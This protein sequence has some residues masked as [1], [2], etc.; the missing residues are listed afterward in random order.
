MGGASSLPAKGC[1]QID[2]GARPGKPPARIEEEEGGGGVRPGSNDARDES[3]TRPSGG[4][5]TQL[6]PD[7]PVSD[8]GSVAGRVGS[9]EDELVCELVSGGRGL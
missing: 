2:S 9:G 4:R 7:V 6:P 3:R 1:P 5:K 8:P